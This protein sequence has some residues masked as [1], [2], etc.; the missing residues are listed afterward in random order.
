M[1]IARRRGALRA[2]WLGLIVCLAALAPVRAQTVS[3]D[4]LL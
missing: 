1:R 3:L 4:D 2:G